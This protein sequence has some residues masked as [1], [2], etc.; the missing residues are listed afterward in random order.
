[1]TVNSATSYDSVGYNPT[2][3]K[4]SRK[5]ERQKAS[6]LKSMVSNIN[7]AIN[8]LNMPPQAISNFIKK[9]ESII[10]VPGDTHANKLINQLNSAGQTL[11]TPQTG[12]PQRTARE[13]KSKNLEAT[14]NNVRE[15]IIQL[16]V[17]FNQNLTNNREW[18]TNEN[19]IRNSAGAQLLRDLPEHIRAKINHRMWETKSS[20]GQTIGRN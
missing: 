16:L 9:I 14:C 6:A 15:Q 17:E 13:S 7:H 4:Q 18:S 10:Q 19:N 20:H 3:S 12:L 11:S 5:Q 1:M 2:P 8:T